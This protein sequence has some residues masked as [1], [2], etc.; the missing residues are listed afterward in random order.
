MGHRYY[1]ALLALLIIGVAVSIFRRSQPGARVRLLAAGSVALVLTQIGLGVLSVMRG[2]PLIPVTAHLGVAAL[3]LV[4]HLVMFVSLERTQTA[5]TV[6]DERAS[7]PA[8]TGSPS[9]TVE[10]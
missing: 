5:S 1:G 9:G 4:T 2:L 6:D 3:I 7:E 8:T 10:A